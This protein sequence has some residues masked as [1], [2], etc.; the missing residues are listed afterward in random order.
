MFERFRRASKADDSIGLGLS[1]VDRIAATLDLD[2]R[3]TNEHEVHRVQVVFR[4]PLAPRIDPTLS[5]ECRILPAR[6]PRK[7]SE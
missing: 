5:V 7:N 1:I 3:Y 2:V 4:E 6:G